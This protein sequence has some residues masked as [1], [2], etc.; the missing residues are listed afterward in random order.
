[1]S[2]NNVCAALFQNGITVLIARPIRSVFRIKTAR[3]LESACA[4]MGFSTTMAV[5]IA[6]SLF[7]I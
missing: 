6:V 7:I 4:L 1:M 5:A 2:E 3:L